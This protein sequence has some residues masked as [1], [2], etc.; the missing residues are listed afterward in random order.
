MACDKWCGL[1][2]ETLKSGLLRIATIEAG[3]FDPPKTVLG[4]LISWQQKLFL[5]TLKPAIENGRVV[6]STSESNGSVTFAR[7]NSDND[8]SPTEW[9][10]LIEELI[11]SLQDPPVR[12]IKRLRQC[13]NVPVA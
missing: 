9:F 10:A 6:I 8:I 2:R 12:Q 3:T 7:T 11:Q 4:I 1:S 13:Y 5:G